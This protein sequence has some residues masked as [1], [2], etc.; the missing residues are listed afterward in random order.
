MSAHHL[1]QNSKWQSTSEKVNLSLASQACD[2]SSCRLAST[3]RPSWNLAAVVGIISCG[4]LLLVYGETR[5]N[6]LGFIVVMVASMLSGL[7]WTITQVL[8]QGTDKTGHGASGGP[9]EVLLQLTPSK[10]PLHVWSVWPDV[11]YRM[12]DVCMVCAV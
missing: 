12:S 10:S 8:L 2:L 5:F 3:C 1:L 6:L 9:V 7:R 4:L 11:S